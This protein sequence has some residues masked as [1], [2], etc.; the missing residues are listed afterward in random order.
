MTELPLDDRAWLVAWER[1]RFSPTDDD[2]IEAMDQA[3]K[4]DA[5]EGEL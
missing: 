2:Y 5:D 4:E 1:G 3:L